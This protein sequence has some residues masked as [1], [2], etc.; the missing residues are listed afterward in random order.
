MQSSELRKQDRLR[1]EDKMIAKEREREG[2]EFKDKD[3]FVTPGYLK[4][5]EEMRRVEQEEKRKEG[6]S[7]SL[8]ISIEILLTDDIER[9]EANAGK[10]GGMLSFYKQYLDTTSATHEA[11]VLASQQQQPTAS[12]SSSSSSFTIQAPPTEKEKSDLELAKEFEE[13]SGKKVEVNDDGEI[14]D[15]RQLMSGGLNIVKKKLGPQLPGS[16]GGGF[17]LPISARQESGRKEGEEEE[18]T[19]NLLHPGQSAEERR[20]A[21]RERQSRE[22]ERQMVELEKKRK[23][24]QEESDKGRVEKVQKRRNDETKVEELKRKAEERRKKREEEM[25]NAKE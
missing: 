1:A 3:Q 2:D 11:A 8:L 17:S 10:K 7:L 16:G 15:K 12:S 22:I 5:Q 4:Q 14:M 13:K 24:D 19:G 21:M 6:E 9:V 25:K 23:R 20:R 18:S